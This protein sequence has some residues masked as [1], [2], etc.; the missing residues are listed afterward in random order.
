MKSNELKWNESQDGTIG[1]ELVIRPLPAK[2]RRNKSKPAGYITMEGHL[3]D[4]EIFMDDTDFLNLEQ[5]TQLR[6]DADDADNEI[7]RRR[8]RRDAPQHSVAAHVI[9]K[10]RTLTS[11]TDYGS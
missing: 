4:D 10:R 8:R 5:V 11:E 7:S 1:S 3:Q 2:F 9:Y 6:H